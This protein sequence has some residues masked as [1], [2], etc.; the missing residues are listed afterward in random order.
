MAETKPKKR[1]RQKR[2]GFSKGFNLKRAGT[3]AFMPETFVDR[4][5]QEKK[6]KELL[7]GPEASGRG[8]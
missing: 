4:K 3:S 6:I 8:G 2:K 5:A 7:A 1:G